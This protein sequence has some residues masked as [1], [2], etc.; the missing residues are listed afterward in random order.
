MEG[1]AFDLRRPALMAFDQQAGRDAA[2]A[3]RR[4]E[5]QRSAGN[6]LLGLPHVGND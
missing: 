1:I 6:E 3:H 4:C 2:D 5:E